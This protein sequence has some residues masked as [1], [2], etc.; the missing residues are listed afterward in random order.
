METLTASINL[1]HKCYTM[2][3]L[4]QRDM[5]V[6]VLFYLY[7]FCCGFDKFLDVFQP[8]R[9]K[10]AGPAAA[11]QWVAV[12]RNISGKVSLKVLY[13]NPDVLL[14]IKTIHV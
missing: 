4:I 1:A 13:I 10:Q 5:L 11:D 9:R 12:S 14:L 7:R 3:Q 8:W 6:L 2:A